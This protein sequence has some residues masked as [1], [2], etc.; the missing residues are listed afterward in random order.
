M[1]HSSRLH[2]ANMSLANDPQRAASFITGGCWW[3]HPQCEYEYGRI[4]PTPIHSTN[5][6]KLHS[7][8]VLLR[9]TCGTSNISC[10][11]LTLLQLVSRSVRIFRLIFIIFPSLYSHFIPGQV[12][13]RM[14]R[15]M[16]LQ[17]SFSL[18]L[19]RPQRLLIVWLE[20]L[21]IWIWPLW[22][23]IL[24]AAPPGQ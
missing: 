23:L 24:L 4:C 7:L 8:F 5:F 19:Q 11:M 3:I 20:T 17:L 6:A 15:V 1:R 14:L 21:S 10:I 2:L 12:H 13:S 22:T 9:D 16:S 18:G